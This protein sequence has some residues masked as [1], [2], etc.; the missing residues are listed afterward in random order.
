MKTVFKLRQWYP[1]A[2]IKLNGLVEG[3]VD[4]VC[5]VF[6]DDSFIDNNFSNNVLLSQTVENDM[7]KKTQPT[8]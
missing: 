6:Y 2:V 5:V 4:L 3:K 1:T 8:T 7:R